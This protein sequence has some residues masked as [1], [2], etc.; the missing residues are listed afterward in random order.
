MK[1]LK[2]SNVILLIFI[3]ALFNGCENSKSSSVSGNAD[4]ASI[5]EKL[6]QYLFNPTSLNNIFLEDAVLTAIHHSMRK[7]EYKGIKQIATFHSNEGCDWINIKAVPKKIKVV[8]TQA[9]V[10]FTISYDA[11]TPGQQMPWEC[12]GTATLV[13]KGSNWIIK[14]I[15]IEGI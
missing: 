2:L 10:D 15:T 13:K 11:G 12:K 1:H 9:D 7:N 4:I 6:P 3:L 8:N 5:I 14:E